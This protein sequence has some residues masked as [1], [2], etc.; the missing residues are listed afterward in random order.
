MIPA[1]NVKCEY[2]YVH[3]DSLSLSTE[4]KKLDKQAYSSYVAKCKE[5]GFTVDPKEGQDRYEAYNAEGYRLKVAWLDYF[6]AA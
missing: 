5:M 6:E 4:K 1:L 3:E 2:A